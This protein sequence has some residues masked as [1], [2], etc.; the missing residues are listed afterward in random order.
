MKNVLPGARENDNTLTIT[1]NASVPTTFARL[2]VDK[3][4]IKAE[5]KT[6]MMA[7]EPVTLCLL[8]LNQSAAQTVKAWGS[9]EVIATEC[10]VLSNSKSDSGLVTDGSATMQAKS[11]CSAGGAAG[12][13]FTPRPYEKCGQQSDPYQNRFAKDALASVGINVAGACNR[14]DYVARKNVTFNVGTGAYT[15]CD[16][17]DICANR[18]VRLGPGLYV[19]FG[20]LHINAQATQG[21]TIIFGDGRWVAGQ[22]DR[23]IDMQ[24]GR[25]IRD[26]R[27]LVYAAVQDA[28]IRAMEQLTRRRSVSR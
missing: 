6:R 26:C 9:G 12:D 16:G 10:A 17:L 23:Y 11:F 22:E 1:A 3:F 20:E 2:V 4:D 8:G 13:G 28:Q 15:F 7:G 21:T 5:A 19:I 27:Q 18:T 25:T 14:T 24:G